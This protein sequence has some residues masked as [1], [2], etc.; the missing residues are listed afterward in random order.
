MT[1][2]NE[3]LRS[4]LAAVEHSL[5]DM[6]GSL[7]RQIEAVEATQAAPSPRPTDQP[8]ALARPASIA[9]MVPTA[10]PVLPR[11]APPMTPS[12]SSPIANR[13]APWPPTAYAVDVGSSLPLPELMRSAHTELFA[14]LEPVVKLRQHA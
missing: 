4:H 14:G 2:D 11:V 3:S 13:R 8:P 7:T 5:D 10:V 6:T 1:T 12:E 9:A